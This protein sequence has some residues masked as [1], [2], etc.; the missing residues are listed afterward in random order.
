[1]K[2]LI[3]YN[4]NI[5]YKEVFVR[6]C[7]FSALEIKDGIV[8]TNSNCRLCGACARKAKNNECELVEEC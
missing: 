2:K 4:E 3:I 7:P 5:V 6:C 8:V 1:M